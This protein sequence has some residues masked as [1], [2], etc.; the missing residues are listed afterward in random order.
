MLVGVSHGVDVGGVNDNYK[1]EVAALD[2]PLE[3]VGRH[4]L[5]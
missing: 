4:R 3:M 5:S 1:S 2:G